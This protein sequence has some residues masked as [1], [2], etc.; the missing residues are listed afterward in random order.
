[1]EKASWIGVYHYSKDYGS[2]PDFLTK[3]LYVIGFAIPLYFLL[4]LIFATRLRVKTLSGGRNQKNLH[5]SAHWAKWSDLKKAG[6]ADKEG[7]VVGG[8]VKNGRLKTLLHNGAEHILCFAPTGS[9]KGIGLVINTL[10]S[11]K[12]STVVLD[13]KGENYEKTAGYR[14]SIGQKIL[15]FDPTAL[16]GSAKFNPLE[17]VRLGT[18]YEIQDVNNISIMLIDTEGKGLK[19]HWNKAGDD[20]LGTLILYFL[21]KIKMQEGRSANLYD[22][23]MAKEST[24]G[25]DNL[26]KEM[27]DFRPEIN[28]VEQDAARQFVLSG[29]QSMLDK[30]SSE[31]SGVNST[32]ETALKTYKDP[33]LRK[34]ISS[35]DFKVLDLINPKKPTSLYLVLPPSDIARLR[36]FIRVLMNVMLNKLVKEL[37]K[38]DSGRL[39][40]MLDEFTS[41]GK[42][43]IFE[44]SLAFMR[45]YGLKAFIIIQDIAQLQK[46]YTREESIISNCHIRIAYAPNK[47]ETA[48][49]LSDMS[50]KTTVVQQKTSKSKN[51]LG[52]TG[53]LSTSLSETARPLLTPDECMQLSGA[54]K[55]KRNPK[56]VV[57][58]GDMLIFPAGFAPILGKQVL[59]F[60]DKELL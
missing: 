44:S 11:W 45:G 54:L 39:L 56:M 37:P 51:T 28:G 7:V 58:G 13:I 16:T 30:V 40:L 20:W 29:T 18:N 10:F 21:Y 35:S 60:Q 26:L 17:E 1:M 6:L 36:P 27:L 22:L 12:H 34:N 50:G 55:S 46:A 53:N 49:V 41:I 52:L 3:Q 59:Y 8:F 24:G 9:G 2:F 47:I 32:V 31:R 57:K 14:A 25:L 19:D 38:G 23:A 43:E 15:K 33:I 42:L 5:G 4:L 48:R